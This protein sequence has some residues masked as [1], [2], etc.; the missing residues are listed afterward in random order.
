MHGYILT[1]SSFKEETF[2]GVGSLQI[3]NFCVHGMTL[4]GQFDEVIQMENKMQL[5]NQLRLAADLH[6]RFCF[7][8]EREYCY[9]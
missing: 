9:I 3:H 2:D 4:W 1:Y 8:A 7:V 5:Q 6:F